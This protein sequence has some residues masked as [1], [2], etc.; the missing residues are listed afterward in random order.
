MNEE[1]GKPDGLHRFC[2]YSVELPSGGPPLADR[3][4]GFHPSSFRLPSIQ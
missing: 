4:P 1:G 2:E 3:A